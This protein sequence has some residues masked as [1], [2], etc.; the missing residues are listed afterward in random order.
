[1]RRGHDAGS[2]LRAAVGR[3]APPV[4]GTAGLLTVWWAGVVAFDLP[5]FL[6][7][8]PPAVAAAIVDQPGYLLH[9]TAVTAVTAA[10][11]YGLAVATAGL[12]GAVLAVSGRV[13][14]AVTPILLLLSTVPKPAVV[15]ILIVWLG[16]GA[17][18]KLVLVWLMCFFPI[19]SATHT[20]LTAT[21]AELVDV[22][23][24]LDAS[25]WQTFTRFR[26]PAALPYLF[27]G[28][29]TALPLA[30]IGA[31]VAELF[32]GTSGLGVVIQTAGTRTDV[33]FAAVVLLAA[34]STGLFYLLTAV[35]ERAAPWIR[36]TT[37]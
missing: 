36:H 31:V 4:L 19:V 20:G 28:L 13:G 15:P 11:G 3:A 35:C 33:A 25:R 23:R 30:V 9:N 22:A 32:G 18:P 17:G 24:S 10:A 34:T 8:A 16:F 21:P 26:A 27:S 1:M 14:R 6:L 2:R 7:P 37:A 12:F 5:A 29:R